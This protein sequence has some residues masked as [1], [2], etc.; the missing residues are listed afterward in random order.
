MSQRVLVVE[1]DRATQQLLDAVLQR[2]SIECA[3]AGDGREALRLLREEQFDA[4]LLDLLLPNVNGFEVLRDLKKND[5]ATLSRVIVMTAA[6]ESTFRGCE[7]L[8]DVHCVLRKPLDLEV[9]TS[10]IRSCLDGVETA[11]VNRWRGKV[12]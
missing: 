4:I 11:A 6:A 2:E 5:R 3:L 9:L 10:E 7:E 8:A 12:P 1:D